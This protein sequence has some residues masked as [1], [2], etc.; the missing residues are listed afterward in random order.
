MMQVRLA[1]A[2]SSITKI[3]R[4]QMGKTPSG[5][6]R[7]YQ[8]KTLWDLNHQIMRLAVLG[9]KHREIAELL[10]VTPATVSNTLNSEIGKRQL[11]V[12]RGAV[13]AETVD[14]A[15]EIQRLAP[16]AVKLLEEMLEDNN[17]G[18]N[19]RVTLIKDVLDRAGY[20]A[21]KVIEGRFIH[22]HLSKEEIDDIK[23]RAAAM[24]APAADSPMEFIEA[25]EVCHEEVA[26]DKING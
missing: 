26:N 5:E 22:A 23:Q 7:K 12:L 19:V 6:P 25:D 2:I 14:V 3:R 11:L 21:P 17:T 15:K 1:G 13:D 16:K 24:L 10:N 18:S 4:S 20:G 8:I 9:H